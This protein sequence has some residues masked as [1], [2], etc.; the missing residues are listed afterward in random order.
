VRA[1]TPAEVWSHPGS[2]WAAKFLAVGNIVTGKV[3]NVQRSTFNVATQFGDIAVNCAHGHSIG[4]DVSLLLKQ[5]GGAE[6]LTVNARVD[7]VV[8]NREQFR[9]K[10]R[11]GLVVNLSDAPEVGSEASVAFAVEC[12]GH[13]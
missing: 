10:L 3:M 1:G 5:P 2:A 13:A 9:V 11:G 7:D 4:E 8:F 12:L 6:G